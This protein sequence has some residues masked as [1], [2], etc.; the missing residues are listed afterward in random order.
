ML[1]ATDQAGRVVLPKHLR[2][3]VGI[4]P[5][6]PIEITVDGAALRL[7][8]VAGSGFIEKDG[9]L[10]L[11]PTGN[12]ITDEDVRELRFADQR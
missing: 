5:G 11:P 9:F 3:E 1:I 6:Q 10:V 12:V 8:P 2:N 7:E 4:V